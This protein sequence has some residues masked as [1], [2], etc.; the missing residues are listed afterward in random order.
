M[1]IFMR[2]LHF[3]F[4]IL[5]LV[6]SGCYK[7]TPAPDPKIEETIIQ[8]TIVDEPEALPEE[9]EEPEFLKFYDDLYSDDEVVLRIFFAFDSTRL[10]DKD[11]GDLDCVLET[12]HQD[13]NKKVLVFGHSD[14][15]GT[16]S[17][18]ETL[19]LRRAEA[20][21]NYFQEKGLDSQRIEIFS[22]GSRYAM[23]RV[24][25]S[26]GSKDRRCDLVLR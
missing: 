19:S 4:G 3:L 23:Q 21:R 8:S 26:G 25:K 16:P 9:P 15:F 12:L 2:S 10:S 18:N 14:W 7:T 11:K 22:L 1:N 20:I 24:S 6:L 17:Y 5:C 13:K